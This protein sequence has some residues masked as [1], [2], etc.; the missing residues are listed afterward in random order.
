M[1]KAGGGIVEQLVLQ[2]P[3]CLHLE[4]PT[5]SGSEQTGPE[6]TVRQGQEQIIRPQITAH[7]HGRMGQ[8]PLGRPGRRFER[9]EAFPGAVVDWGQD[10]QEQ[11]PEAGDC[12]Q[13]APPLT[14]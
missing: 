2:S 5:G 13:I 6:A 4:R 8:G 10:E 3:E 12:R 9:R 7:G 14:A 1:G 11:Q